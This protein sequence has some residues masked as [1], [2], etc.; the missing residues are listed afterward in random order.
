MKK[1]ELQDLR[2]KKI[3]D[4]VKLL[5]DKKL[6]HI[7]FMAEGK[8]QGEKNIKK[9][10]NLRGEIAK[11]STIIREGQLIEQSAQNKGK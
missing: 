4:L 5:A 11:I 7:K 6:D 9:G 2:N 3:E 10:R 8:F 1:R